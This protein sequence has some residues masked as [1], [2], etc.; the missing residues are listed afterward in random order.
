MGE[1]IGKGGYSGQR[2]QRGQKQRHMRARL[3]QGTLRK[4]VAGI[5]SMSCRMAT[6][7]L[8]GTRR[9]KIAVLG[10]SVLSCASAVALR[11]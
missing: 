1:I 11:M 8:D 7:R 5:Q 6:R 3:V 2:K 10:G 9:W 4:R